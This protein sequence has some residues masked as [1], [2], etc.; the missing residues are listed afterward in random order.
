MIGRNGGLIGIRRVPSTSLASGIWSQNEQVLAKRA[1]IWPISPGEGYRYWRFDQFTAVGVV[2]V[3]E[4][5]LIASTGLITGGTWTG[6]NLGGLEEPGSAAMQDGIYTSRAAQMFAPDSGS[7][8]TYDHGSPANA[9]G[10]KY[11]NFFRPATRYITGF[12]VRASSDNVNFATIKIFSGLGAYST[13]DASDV[14]EI[15]P[16]YLF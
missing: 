6:T 13:N 9:I 1:G 8:W 14:N 12:R 4:F 10:F 3:G 11:A 2:E 15:S 5:V 7:F 16:T